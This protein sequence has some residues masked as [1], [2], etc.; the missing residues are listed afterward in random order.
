MNGWEREEGWGKKEKDTERGWAHINITAHQ[1]NNR[2]HEMT[3]ER[4]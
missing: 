2:N 4:N 1:P 3:R